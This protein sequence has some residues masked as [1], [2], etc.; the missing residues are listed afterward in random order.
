MTEHFCDACNRLRLT[1]TGD[2]SDVTQSF[3]DHLF[4][5]GDV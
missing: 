3:I 2:Q 1:A 5:N 4:E